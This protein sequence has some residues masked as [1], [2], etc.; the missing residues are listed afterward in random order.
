MEI[1][2]TGITRP[3]II[4]IYGEHKVGK[5]SFAASCPKP[6]FIQTEAGLEGIKTDALPLCQSYED[7]IEQLEFVATTT[8]YKTLVIDSLDWLEKLIFR[9]VCG[10]HNVEDIG[11]IPFGKGQVAAE[12]KWQMIIDTLTKLNRDKKLIIVLIAH[13][14]VQKFEDPERESYD[15]YVPDLH[16][17]ACPLVCEFVDVIGFAALKTT[18]VS[19]E[20]GFGATVTKAK[21]NGER[22]LYLEARGGFTAGNRYG[23]PAS[24]PLSWDAMANEF[25]KEK[26][27]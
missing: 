10:E 23:L 5:S 4:L 8:D 19:K 1:I 24:L 16:K 7:F 18:V 6:L 14:Q 26:T 20:A 2:K 21:V 15:R 11:K 22:I 17:R 27:V 13:A 12:H 25:K 3:P 9:R